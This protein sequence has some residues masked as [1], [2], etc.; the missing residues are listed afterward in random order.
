MP[1][2]IAILSQAYHP[3]VGGVT[4][5]VDATSR[6]LRERGHDVTVITARFGRSDGVERGVVRMGRNLV[7]P[8]NGAENNVTVGR[9]LERRLQEMLAPERVDL[10]HVHCPL[11]PTLPLHALRVA[12]V[13]IVG[14]FHSTAKSDLAFRL[15]RPVLLRSSGASTGRWPS[16]RPRA[17]TWRGSSRER[18]RSCP[19]AWTWSASGPGS[20]GFRGSTTACRT[21]SSWAATIRGRGSPT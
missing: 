14:T 16:P 6:V 20:R 9:G 4:E 11:S 5:H 15:F 21:S 17:R 10:V 8:F 1:L 3:A 13:P 18:W 12:R 7:V 2:R 19:T